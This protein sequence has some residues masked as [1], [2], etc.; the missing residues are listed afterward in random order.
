MLFQIIS[1]LVLYGCADGTYDILRKT[2]YLILQ[3]ETPSLTELG[4]M[5]L[6]LLREMTDTL[7]HL[8]HNG[9]K[10]HVAIKWTMMQDSTWQHGGENVGNESKERASDT[11]L[12]EPF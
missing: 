2:I 6:Q 12:G 4:M 11:D 5:R 7:L 3:L 1:A 8:Q 9:V 10:L